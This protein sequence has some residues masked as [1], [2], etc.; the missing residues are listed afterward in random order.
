M[1]DWKRRGPASPPYGR[2]IGHLLF[3]RDFSSPVFRR[4]EACDALGAQIKRSSRGHS[5]ARDRPPPHNANTQL[6]G[7]LYTAAVFRVFGLKRVS[8]RCLGASSMPVVDG[9]PL[10]VSVLS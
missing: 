10:R 6:I 1:A 4:G 9:A 8:G 2:R 5:H 3:K 7:A